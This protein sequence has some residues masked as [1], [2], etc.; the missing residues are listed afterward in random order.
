MT[1]V[2]VM[3][4]ETMASTAACEKLMTPSRVVTMMGKGIGVRITLPKFHVYLMI[5]FV[6][7]FVQ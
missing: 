3:D 6:D 7:R 4:T 2:A 1:A 5:L